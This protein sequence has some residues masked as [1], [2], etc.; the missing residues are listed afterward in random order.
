MRDLFDELLADGEA[1]FKRLVAEQQQEFVELEFKTKAD[2]THGAYER[3]DKQNLAKELSAFSNSMG[4]LLVWGI[5]ARNNADGI[6]CAVSLFPIAEI[7]R[8]KA[9]TQS[10]VGSLLAP[11]NDDIYIEAVPSTDNPGSGYLLV[12][13]GRSD[14]RPHRSEAS[15]EKG[16]FKRVGDS[17]YAMEHYDIEDAF[18]RLAPATLKIHWELRERVQIS[19]TRAWSILLNL[20]NETRI[21]ARFPY[22]NLSNLIG[23]VFAPL[24]LGGQRV[25]MPQSNLRGSNCFAGGADH[26]IHPGQLITMTALLVVLQPRSNNKWQHRFEGPI[27][28]DYQCGCLNSLMIESQFTIDRS[29]INSILTKDGIQLT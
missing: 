23:S 22:L 16:Y 18:N 27:S 20:A 17:A 9:Q 11:K 14:R 13:I 8:F 5:D 12:L 29:E 10:L 21:S 15:G 1:A 7:D 19:E 24:E 2:A 26:V 3:H 28:F 25:G 6:D 4:G